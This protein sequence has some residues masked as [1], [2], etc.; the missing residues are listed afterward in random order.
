MKHTHGVALAAIGF[1]LL[2]ICAIPAAAQEVL[3]FPPT[4]SASTPGL[5]MQ[6]SVYKKRVDPKRLPDGETF[7]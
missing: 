3:P 6:D 4:P 7:S 5:S 2:L 1:V